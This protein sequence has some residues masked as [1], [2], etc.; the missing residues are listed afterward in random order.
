MADSVPAEEVVWFAPET[1][2]AIGVAE[3]LAELSDPDQ[4]LRLLNERPVNGEYRRLVDTEVVDGPFGTSAIAPV[5][6][7]ERVVWVD[8]TPWDRE[9]GSGWFEVYTPDEH[10]PSYRPIYRAPRDE[11]PAEYQEVGL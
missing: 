11:W 6:S 4:I 10:G 2:G 1:L 9:D 8:E 7:E 5:F 3:R